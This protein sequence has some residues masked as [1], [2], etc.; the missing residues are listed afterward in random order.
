[1]KVPPSTVGAVSQAAGE[2]TTDQ[3]EPGAPG[4]APAEPATTSTPRW[5]RAD[6]ALVATVVVAAG[7]RLWG[8]ARQSLWY[9]E[10]LTAEAA[11]GSLG[12]LRWYVTERAGIPPTYFGLMWVW[13]RIAGD[14]DAALRLPSV[15]AGIALVPVTYAALREIGQSRTAARLAALLVAVNPMLVWFSQEARPYSLLVLL[16]TASLWLLARY[17]NSGARRDLAIWALVAALAIAFHYIAVFLVA[18]EAVAV[19]VWRR[20]AWRDLAIGG[21]PAAVVLLA[22]AP[23]GTQQFSQRENHNWIVDFTLRAR[24]DDSAHGA[25]VGPSPPSR[26]LWIVVAAAAAMAVVLVAVRGDRSE[27]RGALLAGGFGLVPAVLAVLAAVVGVDMII[28]RYLIVSLAAAIAMVA[29]GL[30]VARVPRVVGLALAAVITAASVV[31]IA[32]DAREPELQRA[33][34]SAIADAHMRPDDEGG[35]LLVLNVHGFLG[36]PLQ[37]YL[38]GERILH[39]GETATVARIDVVVAKPTTKP[40]NLFVGLACA[41]IF[42]GAPPPQPLARR[43]TLDERIDLDQFVLE[44][45]VATDGR[46]I[47]VGPPDVVAA[48]DL[49]G[50]LVLATD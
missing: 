41:L 34:W 15:L 39:S 26:D 46:P 2:R 16:G 50:S 45:Y 36:W 25:L 43:L 5:A 7:F 12:H 9:D 49:G 18:L 35:R 42:L 20:P 31:T 33:E 11:E 37:R 38:D 6:L 3:D 1:V 8:F 47:T 10:W 28:A 22:L 17:W 40:C 32:A 29:V 13:A 27:R 44:R 19:L 48:Q 14:G 24:M 23:F 30:S 21:I 4:P